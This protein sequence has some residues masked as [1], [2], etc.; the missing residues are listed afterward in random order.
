MKEKVLIAKNQAL[1]ALTIQNKKAEKTFKM[2]LHTTI[3]NKI[4]NKYL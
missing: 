2:E 1:G 4:K 3:A